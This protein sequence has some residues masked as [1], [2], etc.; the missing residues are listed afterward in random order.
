MPL[1]PRRI[2]KIPPQALYFDGVD[3]YVYIGEVTRA[4]P[5]TLVVTFY[6]LGKAGFQ[7]L[8]GKNYGGLAESTIQFESSFPQPLYFYYYDGSASQKL[9]STS[10]R[11]SALT[12]YTV[13]AVFDPSLSA[14]YVNGTLDKTFT[15]AYPMTYHAS[16]RFQ[17]SGRYPD[18]KA[19]FNGYVSRVLVY[20][21]YLSQSEAQQLCTNPDN[22]VRD[23]LVLWLHWDSID[24]VA[25]K[26]WDKSGNG[27]HGTI[28]GATLRQIIKSPSRILTPSGVPAPRR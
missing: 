27:N 19:L 7:S 13:V 5:R 6:A 8:L 10:T 17:V 11:F 23:S 14:V 22:P 12:W 15:P 20:E 21:R 16:A 18:N 3:D 2:Q 26:W 24:P 1:T 25:G 28:Y 4:F 9:G